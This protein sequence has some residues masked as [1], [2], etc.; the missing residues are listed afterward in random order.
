MTN[1]RSTPEVTLHVFEQ[2]GSWHWAL[3]L[4]RPHGIGKKVVAY[5]DAQF[6]TETEAHAAG[7]REKHQWEQDAGLQR[8]AL[9]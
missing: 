5:S 4:P 8:T 6:G 9:A 3:T 1:P 2:D 7:A